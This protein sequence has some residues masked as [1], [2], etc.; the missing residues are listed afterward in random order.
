[1]DVR[2][3][4]TRARDLDAS[5]IGCQMIVGDAFGTLSD[6]DTDSRGRVSGLYLGGQHVPVTRGTVAVRDTLCTGGAIQ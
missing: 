3:V 2:L 5:W 1:M 6:L 4:R